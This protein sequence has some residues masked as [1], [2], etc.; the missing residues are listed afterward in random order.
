MDIP[1]REKAL[2]FAT[3]HHHGQKR[4]D[5]KDYITHPIAV[6]EIAQR[7]YREHVLMFDANEDFLDVLKDYGISITFAFWIRELVII[8]F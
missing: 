6:A 7:I 1:L 8:V 4:K 2:A 3:K 5:G